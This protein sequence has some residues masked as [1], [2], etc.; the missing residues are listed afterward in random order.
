MTFED[1]TFRIIPKSIEVAQNL[2]NDWYTEIEYFVSFEPMSFKELTEDSLLNGSGKHKFVNMVMC[3]AADIEPYIEY[4][5][6]V[7]HKEVFFRKIPSQKKKTGAFNK[8][9]TRI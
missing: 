4:D 9:N 6:S 5:I 1:D 3:A 2:L 7:T 8:K